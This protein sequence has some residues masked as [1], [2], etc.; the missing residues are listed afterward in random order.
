MLL[1]KLKLLNMVRFIQHASSECVS[2]SSPKGL[3]GKPLKVKITLKG[4]KFFMPERH[5]K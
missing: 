5:K 1:K 3:K 2:L 4:Y